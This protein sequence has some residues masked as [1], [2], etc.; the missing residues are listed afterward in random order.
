LLLALILVVL[1]LRNALVAFYL[2]S[3][4]DKASRAWSGHPAAIMESGLAEIGRQAANGQA[5]DPALVAHLLEAYRKSPLSPEP[6]MVRGV[7][8]QTAGNQVLAGRA[9]IAARD[10]DPRE[11]GARYFLAD[12]YL[13]AG[14]SRD[15][16]SEISALI[17]LVPASLPQV[18]PYLA[19]YAR[20]PGAA[21]QV[22]ETIRNHAL[23]ETE[24]LNKLAAEPGNLK[25]IMYLWS[26][27]GGENGRRWQAP[28]LNS[29]VAA[30]HFDEAR[31][32]WV[33]FT[34]I[35]P[36]RD[37][38]FDRE[39]AM[40][41][42]PPFGWTLVSGSA[43]VAEPQPGGKLH[44]IYYGRHDLVLAS[45][46]LSLTPGKYRFAMKVA[47]ASKA[48]RALSWSIRCLPSKS[49]LAAI[50]LDRTQSDGMVA[51]TFQ[52]PEAGCDGQS[53]E[54]AARAPEIPEQAELTVSQLN[55]ERLRL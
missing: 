12:H 4:P 8:A 34:G 2:S 40:V 29:L 35:S 10:R 32:S 13:R 14:N 25:L 41:A 39:F 17:R 9:F 5:I 20:Q 52:V 33:R 54:L 30:G 28:L 7:Q 42:P 6:F 45:Q 37:Q 22:R 24:L 53:L 44:L 1:I 16:L 46:L 38:L 11:R 36:P 49:E 15:G 47:G 48:A 43:G 23:I 50:P 3:E 55:L 19:A 27:K 51:S 31:N 21:P 26:G 18:V